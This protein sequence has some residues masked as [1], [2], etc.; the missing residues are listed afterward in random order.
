[1]GTVEDFSLSITKSRK[2][3]SPGNASTWGEI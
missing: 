2:T 1:M 3:P